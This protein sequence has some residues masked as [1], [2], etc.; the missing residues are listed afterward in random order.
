MLER[1]EGI[2]VNPFACGCPFG[3]A[4]KRMFLSGMSS[5]WFEMRYINPRGREGS[6]APVSLDTRDFDQAANE[7]CEKALQEARSRVHPLLQHAGLGRLDRRG[8]FL[9]AFKNALEHRVARTLAA[10]QP[11]VQAIYVY[12]DAVMENMETWDGSVRL[13]LKVPRLSN[14]VRRLGKNL[15]GSLVKYLEQLGWPRIRA[16]HSVLEIHQ[17]TPGELRHGIGY[18]A[19]FFAVHTA[20]VRIWPHDHKR[21]R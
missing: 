6:T 19:M 20:P 2:L 17:V 9:K 5:G 10:W 18:G 13:L 16:G 15:D 21:S 11:G 1:R 7:I 3:L 4:A 12:D 8:D 14:A